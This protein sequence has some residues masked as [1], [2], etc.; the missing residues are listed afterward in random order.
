MPKKKKKRKTGITGRF[1][2]RYGTKIRQRVKSIEEE[3]KG[4]HECPKC[5]AEKVK[6]VGTGIWK[7]ERCE[8]K[9]AA[10]AYKPSITPIKKKVAEEA[11]EE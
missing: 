5:G 6:R 1:G 2:S 9:F 10:K 3:M 4:Y 8:T 7:C 11:T